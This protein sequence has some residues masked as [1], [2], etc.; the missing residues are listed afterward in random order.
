MCLYPKQNYLQIF[1]VQNPGADEEKSITSHPIN[2]VIT[3]A[4]VNL[5]VRFSLEIQEY[6][7]KRKTK[8]Q[9]ELPTR[10]FKI[11]GFLFHASSDMKNAF[12]VHAALRNQILT[13]C[14]YSGDERFYSY[15]LD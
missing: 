8:Q 7:N 3:S 15:I 13:C 4:F 5:I 11:V 14:Y 12:L 6:N 1:L 10:L 9:H 2:M